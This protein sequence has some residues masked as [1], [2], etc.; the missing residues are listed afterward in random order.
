MIMVRAVQAR[1]A[2]ARPCR[3][4]TRRGMLIAVLAAC[5]AV[6][7]C[8]EDGGG[9]DPPPDSAPPTSQETSPSPEPSPIDAE[10]TPERTPWPEPV[11]PAAMDRDD[12]E[13]AKAAAVY[14][15][16]LYTYVYVS[17][18]L[19]AWN[20]MSHPECQFCSGA[21]ESILELIGS[22]GR[23]EGGGLEV[24]AVV[25]LEPDEQYGHYRVGIDG[26]EDSYRE[27]SS[28]GD[29]V[30]T[31]NGGSVHYNVAVLRQDREW[32]IRG[33]SLGGD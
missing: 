32:L 5:L 13:G 7:G 23:S 21:S 31:A 1:S 30:F 3:V 6:S 18:D 26:T 20:E 9:D 19:A 22:G 17:G 12:I 14:F 16:E 29:I 15:M 27:F 4:G 33:V 24:A 8:A 28:D 10:P 11:R 2:P 25:A